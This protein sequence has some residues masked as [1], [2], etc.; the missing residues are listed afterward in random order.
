MSS[1][2]KAIEKA[3]PALSGGGGLSHRGPARGCAARPLTSALRWSRRSAA[4]REHKGVAR[5]ARRRQ[6]PLPT[7]ASHRHTPRM[8]RPARRTPNRTAE[9]RAPRARASS[10]SHCAGPPPPHPTRTPAR[11]G[12]TRGHR[13][14]RTAPIAPAHKRR[15]GSPRPPGARG[16]ARTPGSLGCAIVVCHCSTAG[17]SAVKDA[18]APSTCRP[19]LRQQPPPIPTAV[20][21]TPGS[22]EPSA[23]P[24]E[25]LRYC[26]VSSCAPGASPIC[27]RHPS[28]TS[29]TPRGRGE[30]R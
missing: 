11:R 4:P 18:T 1:T 16:A 25:S 28:S 8:K 15:V 7:R 20:A 24:H 17:S 26:V 30:G 21:R 3:P 29:K 12:R 2:K 6:G 27:G 9:R 13:P 23:A 5:G 10:P 19:P 14:G 22:P